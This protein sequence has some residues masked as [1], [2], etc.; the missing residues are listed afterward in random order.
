MESRIGNSRSE[1][2]ILKTIESEWNI[3]NFARGEK[4]P[5]FLLQK[6]KKLLTI[7]HQ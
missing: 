4:S 2:N 3:Y 1:E 5:L 6:T 7:G